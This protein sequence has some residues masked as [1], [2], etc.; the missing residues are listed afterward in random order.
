MF[1]FK[2]KIVLTTVS[3]ILAGGPS[4]AFSLN[5]PVKLPNNAGLLQKTAL[6]S[7]KTKQLTR[8]FDKKLSP[9]GFRFCGVDKKTGDCKGKTGI[10]GAGLGGTVVPLVLDIK[11]F[12]ILSRK[13]IGNNLSF[14]SKFK[15]RV[16]G[17]PPACAKTTGTITF[18]SSKVDELNYKTFYC[19]W[20]GVGNVL[21]K[22]KLKIDDVDLKTRSF[23]GKY[24]V[25][26]NGTGNVFGAGRFKAFAR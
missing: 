5:P 15:A 2:N 4:L 9:K 19:N 22:V 24:T 20:L 6:G 25:R 12:N 14:K 13:K 8:L 10:R 7:S 3:L 1:R 18:S 11:S 26:F 16:N 21:T 23:S 17:I